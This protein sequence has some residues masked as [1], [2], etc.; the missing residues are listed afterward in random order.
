MGLV[1]FTPKTSTFRMVD[2]ALLVAVQGAADRAVPDE[3]ALL[4]SS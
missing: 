2:P 1:F 4:A 3:Q